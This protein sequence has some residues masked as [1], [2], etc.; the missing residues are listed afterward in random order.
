MVTFDIPKCVYPY[1]FAYSFCTIV[2]SYL[3]F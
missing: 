2:V 3:E 1:I